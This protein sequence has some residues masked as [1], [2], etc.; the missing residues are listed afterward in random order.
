[1]PVTVAEK[2]SEAPRAPAVTFVRV[3]ISSPLI[4]S[5]P[6]ALMTIY[7]EDR[8]RTS[9]MLPIGADFQGPAN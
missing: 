5:P 1:M 2:I 3:F 9:V 7:D 6:V 4:A 8:G